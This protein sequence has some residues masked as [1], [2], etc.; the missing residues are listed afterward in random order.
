MSVPTLPALPPLGLMLL[1]FGLMLLAVSCL[2]LLLPQWW[3]HNVNRAK[4]AALLGLP[5]LLWLAWRQPLLLRHTLQEYVAFIIL[6]AA[7]YVISSHIVLEGRLP[8]TPAGNTVVLAV[9]GLLASLIGTTGATLLLVRPLLRSNAARPQRA[10][11]MVFFI[12]VVGNLGGLLTPLGDPPLYLGFLRGVPFTWTL[13]LWP[14]WLLAQS[15]VLGVFYGLDWTLQRRAALAPGATAAGAAAVDD[16][17]ALAAVPPDAGG[18]TP[19]PPGLA[20]AAALPGQR[21][22]ADAD[23]STAA[24]GQAAAPA[25]QSAAAGRLRL[26]GGA[27]FLALAAVVGSVALAGFGVLSQLQAQL[28]MLLLAAL[29]WWGSAA[30][31]RRANSF[32][33]E[34]IA[35]VAIVF[36]GIF[37]T[38]APALLVLQVHG[39]S[40][41]QRLGLQQPWQFFWL[42]GLLSSVLD[43]APTYLTATASASAL[44]GTDPAALQ[45]LCASPSGAALLRAIAT[46]A[47]MMG[48]NTYL[49]NGPNFMVKAVAEAH[50]TPMPSF[51]GYMAYSG[52]VLLP[53]FGLLTWLFY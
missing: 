30:A 42:T 31:L 33:W 34:P 43:N 17:T 16:L 36:A 3:Q 19:G 51:F 15:I 35:E 28:G 32:S 22:P 39:E 9:G 25:G 13:Q 40:S 21:R 18:A 11:V 41:L 26:R 10:H 14:Q 44:V 48:A 6:L 38:M 53:L 20:A 37:A 23:S 7:L 5:T 50:G 4:V 46:G 47:V 29:T 52:I 45:Q 24:I 49:G 2:P 8:A 1:P 27:N 12:F